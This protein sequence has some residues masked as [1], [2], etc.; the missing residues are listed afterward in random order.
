MS[1][2]DVEFIKIDGSVNAEEFKKMLEAH[3]AW[4]NNAGGKRLDL[5]NKKIRV[6]DMRGINLTC[7]VLRGA[8]LRGA[9]LEGAVLNKADL[10]E[11]D[12]TDATLAGARLYGADL[13]RACC[14]GASLRKADLN[15]ADLRGADLREADLTGADL[16][17]AD[18]R[19]VE[20]RTAVLENAIGLPALACPEKG[21]FIG[22]KYALAFDVKN[23]KRYPVLIELSIPASAKRSSGTGRKCRCSKAKVKRIVSM[24]TGEKVREA[25][26]KWDKK[27]KYVVGETVEVKNFDENRWKECAPGIHF[28]M[29]QLEVFRFLFDPR[30]GEKAYNSFKR[31]GKIDDVKFY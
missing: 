20:I 5:S 13:K 11:T 26:S 25:V 30:S 1:I 27:F 12:L 19:M 28:F 15:E 21:S 16:T 2:K 23:A 22:W 10:R 6:L 3:E 4:L 7:A 24:Y 9:Y 31:N 18:V 14:I 29:T 8:N 17:G